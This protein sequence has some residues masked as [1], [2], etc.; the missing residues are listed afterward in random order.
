MPSSISSLKKCTRLLK[1][2]LSKLHRTWRNLICRDKRALSVNISWVNGWR[3]FSCIAPKTSQL[4]RG[5]EVEKL[6][7][8]KKNWNPK[9]WSPTVSSRVV[10]LEDRQYAHAH[11]WVDI[12]NKREWTMDI[13]HPP[14]T[15][16]T[17]THPLRHQGRQTDG[18]RIR[19]ELVVHAASQTHST[20][21]TLAFERAQMCEMPIIFITTCQIFPAH[22]EMLC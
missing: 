3:A 14:F 2:F 22:D 15:H 21:P 18:R 5:S 20:H 4:S 8:G 11:A 9:E 1:E 6:Y 17:L 7:Q 16:S 12:Q 13:G 19:V 10:S